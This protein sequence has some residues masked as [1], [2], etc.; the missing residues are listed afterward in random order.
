MKQKRTIGLYIP[1][2][3]KKK[4]KNDYDTQ[5]QKDHRQERTEYSKRW[6][7][8]RRKKIEDLLGRRPPRKQIYAKNGLYKTKYYHFTLLDN[9]VTIGTI[10]EEIIKNNTKYLIIRP[11]CKRDQIE[12]KKSDIIKME[13]KIVEKKKREE[14]DHEYLQYLSTVYFAKYKGQSRSY[15]ESTSSDIQ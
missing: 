8:K 7:L 4:R 11:Y 12:V 15:Q 6:R 1:A 10:I 2:K 3:I 5:Y 14:F 9:T 13:Y